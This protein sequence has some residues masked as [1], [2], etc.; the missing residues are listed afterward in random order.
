MTMTLSP[1]LLD[2]QIRVTPSWPVPTCPAVTHSPSYFLTSSIRHHRLLEEALPSATSPPT[3]SSIM[4]E[5]KGD[6]KIVD[7]GPIFVCMIMYTLPRKYT[8][9][10]RD[11][12]TER[13]REKSL[14]GQRHYINRGCC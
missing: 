4:D 11:R 7:Y 10:E 8:E 14:E 2:S 5:E 1:T 13:Q 6:L 9:R 3:D 12:E